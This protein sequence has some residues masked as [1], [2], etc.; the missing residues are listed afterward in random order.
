MGDRLAALRAQRG[1]TEP[2]P[3]NGTYELNPVNTGVQDDF[4]SEIS[5]IQG[6]IEEFSGNVSRVS[7][8]H[9][10]SLNAV[11]DSG[12]QNLQLLDDQV[13]KTRDL[14]NQIK[15]R[16]EALK[17]QPSPP[18]QQ[19]ARG[20]QVKVVGNKFVS[21]LQR[22]T[23]VE[24]EY[25][26]KQRQRVERQLKIVRPDASPEEIA[27]AADDPQGG[28][29][30]FADALQNSSR[31]GESR[32]A[33]RE[34]QDRH[35]DFLKIE[36]T[37]TELAQLMNDMAVLIDEQDQ[38]VNNIEETTKKVEY[39]TEQGLGQTNKAVDYARSARGKRVICFWLSVLLIIIIVAAVAGAIC[40]Q[41]KCSKK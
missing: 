15:K 4:Y 37:I 14:G 35:Q 38:V 28:S 21:A 17:R 18:G 25:R 20:D 34:V 7:E 41:G 27:A 5:D 1:P 16:I 12:Q 33:Y 10:S 29:Q 39:D 31:Y 11:G 3:Q 40:G 22:Y 36:R 2:T 32:A 13:I 19:K 23:Q 30:V 24:K 9:S 6:M 8:M 26:Q